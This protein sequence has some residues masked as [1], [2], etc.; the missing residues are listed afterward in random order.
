MK[1]TIRRVRC[2]IWLCMNNSPQECLTGNDPQLDLC[3]SLPVNP[4]VLFWTRPKQ[5]G[6]SQS[7]EPHRST[8]YTWEGFPLQWSTNSGQPSPCQRI[9]TPLSHESHR[10]F[11]QS[12][13]HLS[14]Q[15]KN[16]KK[17]KEIETPYFDF[18]GSAMTCSTADCWDG[19]VS[20]LIPH[21]FKYVKS[22]IFCSLTQSL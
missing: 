11:T 15:V 22:H 14:S 19:L 13:T 5:P 8:A 3:I 2:P 12:L 20:W 6:G 17:K 18:S 10:H 16:K 9:S 4:M 7:P 21:C 1:K